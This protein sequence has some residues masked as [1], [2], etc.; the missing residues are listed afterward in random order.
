MKKTLNIPV[1][2]EA[3][4]LIT[5]MTYARV[6][7]WYGFTREDL[8]MDLVMPK[9]AVGHAPM[10]AVLWLC[11]G[12]FCVV[13]RSVWMPQM[14]DLAGRLGG[15]YSG[16]ARVEEMRDAIVRSRKAVRA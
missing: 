5:G 11:G 16:I 1:T 10:P 6:P 2:H 13:D 14:I 8:K 9:N 7:S 4:T 15:E 12:A 3:L